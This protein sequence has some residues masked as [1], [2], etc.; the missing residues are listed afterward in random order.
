MN[1]RARKR[2][3]YARYRLRDRF[4]LT[5]EDR[6][7]LDEVPVGREF[8]SKDYERLENLDAFTQGRIDAQKA[9][10]LLGIDQDALAAMVEHEGLPNKFVT[11][12]LQSMREAD[13]GMLEPY[14]Y[15][16]D[17]PSPDS[18]DVL[19]PAREFKKK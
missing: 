18:L 19:S 17:D 15:S 12:T 16:N 10:R 7:W 4:M 11:D 6:A 5:T 2:R 3:I 13:A 1:S 9:M 8:G 14:E